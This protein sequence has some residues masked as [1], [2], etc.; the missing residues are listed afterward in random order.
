MYLIPEHCSLRTMTSLQYQAAG[1]FSKSSTSVI[2][3]FLSAEEPLTLL[4]C[5]CRRLVASLNGIARKME[6]GRK[7][8]VQDEQL[9]AL[10]QGWAH[11]ATHSIFFFYRH[12]HLPA[13]IVTLL[14]WS[15]RMVTST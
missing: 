8:T 9:L 5:Q 1:P 10:A 11:A 13:P 14:A 2:K 7:L 15:S 12:I 3:G 6:G 4:G